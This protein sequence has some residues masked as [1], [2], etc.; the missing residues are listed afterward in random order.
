MASPTITPTATRT[1][2]RYVYTDTNCNCYANCDTNDYAYSY[3]YTY[4]D[5]YSHAHN[6]SY[7]YTNT[8]CLPQSNTETLRLACRE[9]IGDHRPVVSRI[10]DVCRQSVRVS[11]GL[12]MPAQ[13]ASE[14]APEAIV[15]RCLQLLRNSV[16]IGLTRR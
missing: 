11:G 12:P 4:A 5:S 16:T 14:T 6:K 2:N 3:S 7:P 15:Q 1:A 10:R 9:A 13:N 8:Y